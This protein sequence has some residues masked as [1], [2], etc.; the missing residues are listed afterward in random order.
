MKG[1]LDS[2]AEKLNASNWYF[3]K[4]TI[5]LELKVRGLWNSVQTPI[6][7]APTDIQKAEDDKARLVILQM[8]ERT[9][10]DK[11]S[12]AR[13]AYE[14]FVK[15]QE[16]HEGAA[17]L[18][19]DQIAQEFHSFKQKKNENI[20]DLVGRFLSI[21]SRLSSTSY[22]V[23][24]SAKFHIFR[25]ALKEEWVQFFDFWKLA[26]RDG[27]F[28]ELATAIK[29]RH[30]QDSN[31]QDSGKGAKE[32]SVAFLSEV[33]SEKKE[34]HK[35]V[36]NKTGLPKNEDTVCNF[37]KQ[38]G[39]MWRNCFKLRKEM[40]EKTSKKK[41]PNKKAL[42]GS[43]VAFVA[44]TAD[45]KVSHYEVKWIA[46][47]AATRHMCF[48]RT[49]LDDYKE[50][51]FK[52]PIV[53]AGK[54][55][56]GL[57]SGNFHF[58]YKGTKGCLKDVWY[59]PNIPYNLLSTNRAQK[60]GYDIIAQGNEQ[61]MKIVKDGEVF[62]EGKRYNDSNL[63]LV[64]FDLKPLYRQNFE[65][66]MLGAPLE[67]WHKRFGHISKQGVKKLV[68]QEAVANLRIQEKDVDC[69]SCALGKVKKS[70]HPSTNK[71]LGTEESGVIHL[72]TSGPM[73][74]RSLGGSYHLVVGVEDLSNYRIVETVAKKSDVKKAVEKIILSFE[75]ES[76]R[77]VKA[78]KTDNGTEYVNKDLLD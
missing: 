4:Q 57:G 63:D 48:D 77:P 23:E 73:H 75:M 55:S 51:D 78:I 25:Q 58:T 16:N 29:M 27:S 41:K 30:H 76:R 3:W 59:V 66:A 64:M 56:F 67:D 2:R 12:S 5:I 65:Q 43:S 68:S 38:K 70:P 32:A 35:K 21:V 40:N 17:E 61:T 18:R 20:V 36:E 69:V 60:N 39:H 19:K 54:N 8:L 9:E 22:K 24:E 7:A 14:L 6:P 52:Y 46:D 10:F 28:E 49:L 71:V 31:S 53:T 11:V 1:I 74:T 44:S 45:P 26:N 34:D 47:S 13:N 50:F 62:L 72:D 37:C 42:E 33:S 15:L